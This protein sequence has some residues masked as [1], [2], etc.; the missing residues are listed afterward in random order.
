MYVN[1]NVDGDENVDNDDEN[2]DSNDNNMDNDYENSNN[3]VK[4]IY[5]SHKDDEHVNN[6]G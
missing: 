5:S 4:P 6:D 3:Y 1:N 2:D